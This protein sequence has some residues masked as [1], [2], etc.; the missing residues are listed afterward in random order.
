MIYV[1]E[2]KTTAPAVFKTAL[3]EMVYQTLQKLS[4]PFERVDTDE[5]IT[6]EDCIRINE[7]LHMKTVKTL[8]LCNRQ[9]TDFY[10]FITTADKPFKTKD[11][12][13]VLNISRLSFAPVTLL[14]SMLGT[15]VGAATIFGVMLDKENKIQVV[16]DKDILSEEWYGCS[17][18]TTTGY[19]KVPMN[20]MMPHF[21]DYAGHVPRVIGLSS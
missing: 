15:S 3:Q 7:Q 9:Q 1:S 14:E 10:L 20:W 5:A 4:V 6:M 13:A 19:M 8:F 21:L 16:I 2:S 11:L 18:G 12:S 17:D